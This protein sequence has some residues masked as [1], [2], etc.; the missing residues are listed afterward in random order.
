MLA[1]FGCGASLAC[2]SYSLG[3][4]TITEGPGIV[5]VFSVKVFLVTGYIIAYLYLL[6]CYPTQ[7]RAT[8]L[9]FVMVVG[10]LGGAACPFVYDGLV[11][12]HTHGKWFSMIMASTMMV[13]SVICC[14]LPYET[15]DAELASSQPPVPKATPRGSRAL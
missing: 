13:A 11:L 2:T 4:G 7:F 1:F 15:K 6:E 8:G 12:I 5:S 3:A 14:F 9:A 10:R